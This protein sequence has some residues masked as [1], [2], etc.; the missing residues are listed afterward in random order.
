LRFEFHRVLACFLGPTGEPGDPDLGL[1]DLAGELRQLGAPTLRTA[2][3]DARQYRLD[4]IDLVMLIA[5]PADHGVRE[6]RGEI[7]LIIRRYSGR[8]GEDQSPVHDL[9][10][11]EQE[12]TPLSRLD[13][14]TGGSDAE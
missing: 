2:D 11:A 13:R 4:I 6:I 14:L 9:D 8:E 5:D 10:V 7:R 12:R 1:S 3:P